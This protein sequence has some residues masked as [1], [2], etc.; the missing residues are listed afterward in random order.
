MRSATSVSTFRAK[1]NGCIR[2]SAL[3]AHVL[4]FTDAAGHGVTG[5][6]GAFDSRLID[7]ATRGE[8]LALSIDARVQGVLESEL[9]SAVANLEAHRRRGDH[10]RR[11]HRRS[12]AMTSL[13]TFNPNK[14][15]AREYG[16][17][18]QCGDA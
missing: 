10:P 9:G 7:K 5:V 16:G 3:A 11:P 15:V 14:L 12:A 13:P 6:E 8:P 4:G 17:A 2:S 18:A 1:R